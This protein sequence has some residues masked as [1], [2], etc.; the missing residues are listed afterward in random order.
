MAQAKDFNG[1][2]LNGRTAD[3]NG[4]NDSDKYGNFF[5][6]G[7]KDAAVAESNR[8]AQRGDDW[9]NR[10]GQQFGQPIDYTQAN[11]MRDQAQASRGEQQYGLSLA[12]Q[13]MEGRAPS[14]AM[15]SGQANMEQAALQQA[16]AMASPRQAMAAQ[17]AGASY[18]GH[19]AAQA[20]QGYSGEMS[21]GRGAYLGG[22]GD[23]R[24]GD[25][26]QAG[27]DLGREQ[28]MADAHARQRS[29]EDQMAG[30]YDQQGL[31]QAQLNTNMDSMGTNQ[32]AQRW[33]EAQRQKQAAKDRAQRQTAAAVQTGASLAGSMAGM[34][35]DV[36]L[37]YGIAPLTKGGR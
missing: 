10:Y 36:R 20:A 21:A 26:G 15:I 9:S 7:S 33:A 16:G 18:M 13:Q 11:A 25:Y 12:Q 1:S 35:S 37:K 30:F 6:G 24:Q 19:G 27:M 32:Q 34:A 4:F 31:G 14:A 2:S 17:Q 22:A 29:L 5:Y 23:M 3:F 28:A 8:T